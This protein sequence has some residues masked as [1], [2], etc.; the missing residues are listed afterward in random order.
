MALEAGVGRCCFFMANVHTGQPSDCVFPA[1]LIELGAFAVSAWD[2]ADPL[3][4]PPDCVWSVQIGG[5]L[6][7]VHVCFGRNGAGRGGG[8]R[9]GGISERIR[10]K[11]I[12]LI[13]S[14][15]L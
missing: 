4:A 9:R 13:L 8:G 5:L 7:F 2:G 10:K 3:C 1:K 15:F 6:I 11:D 14:I 12:Q